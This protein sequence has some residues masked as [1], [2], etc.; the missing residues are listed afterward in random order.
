LAVKGDALGAFMTGGLAVFVAAPCLGPLLSAPMGAAVMLPP[1][2]GMAIFLALALGFAAP[3]AAF[4]FFPALARLLPKPGPWTDLFKQTLSFPVFAGAAFFL[5]VLT[6]QTGTA[7]LARALAGAIVLGFAAFLFEKSKG[8]GGRRAVA[9]LAAGALAIGAV[10]TTINVKLV[11]TATAKARKYGRLDALAYDAAAIETL[12]GEGRG[13]FVDFTAAWC[14]TCQ[15]NKMT[16]L[17][18]RTLAEAFAAGDVALMTA[19]WTR[20]DPEITAALARFGANG[21]PLYVYYPPQGEA[22]VLPQP[23]TERAVIDA[24][25]GGV[26]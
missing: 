18:S 1:A 22:R 12:R 13:V 17:S 3:F 20:R 2:S 25:A 21:V 19:D 11:E 4:S 6:E 16:V 8:E 5:W 24:I 23:L 10:A 26:S 9:R 7:G 15:V 14:V